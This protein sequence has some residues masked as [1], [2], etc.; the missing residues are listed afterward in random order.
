MSAPACPGCGET[1]VASAPAKGTGTAPFFVERCRACGLGWTSPA[2]SDAEIADWYPQGYYGDGN[3]RFHPLL[4]RLVRLFQTRRARVIRRRAASG[5]VLDVGCGRGFL[6]KTLRRLGFEPHGVELCEHS[7]WHARNRLHIPVHVGALSTAPYAKGAFSAVV[8]WHTLE[9]FAKPFEMLAL[10]H[11]LLK[12]GG[13]LV[14]AVPNS[15][16]LQAA[17]AGTDWFHLDVPRHYW[18]FGASSLK[19]ALDRAGFTV[20]KEDHFS[21]EQNPYGWLQSLLNLVTPRFNF[22]YDWLKTKSARTAPLRKNPKQ[23]LWTLGLAAVGAP[24]AVL[25]TVLEAGL[26]RGGTVEMYAVKRG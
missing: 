25:L 13:L 8:F 15:E 9:H 17:V 16:S 21:F 18:H 14:V 4:E 6:L 19:R 20:V 2:L 11:G 5:K 7:A 26:R 24:L 12:P 1:R 3:A 22:L 23:A 10:A